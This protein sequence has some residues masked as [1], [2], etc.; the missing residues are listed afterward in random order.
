M[1]L[2]HTVDNLDGLDEAFHPLYTEKDGKFVLTGV[3]GVKTQAD[4][5]AVR[6]SLEKER[7]D[8]KATKEK[9]R[10]FEAHADDHEAVLSKLDRFDELEAASKGKIDDG[11]INEMVETR[12]KAKTAP[13]E[14][15]VKKLKDDNATLLTENGEL[16][17]A[18]KRRI[19]RDNIREAGLKTKMRESAIE[20]AMLLGE[21]VLDID[22]TGKVVTRDGVGVTPGV[23]AEVWLTEMQPKRTHWWPESVG[24]GG[25]GSGGGGGGGTNP[26]TAEGWNT[27]DQGRLFR[28]NPQ[29]AEQLAKSAGTTIGGPKPAPRK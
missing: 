19:V 5:D 8:H 28:E 22:E 1:K 9:F 17:A 14:R 25:K 27:T 23:D 2:K 6:R 16:K 4:V 26:F 12:L 18:D 13:L 15:E 11:K 24:G 3:E 20:D 10:P 21:R 7:A 29:K